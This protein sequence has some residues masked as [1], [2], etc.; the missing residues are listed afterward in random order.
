VE[1]G[2]ALMVNAW[3]VIGG[4]SSPTGEVILYDDDGNHTAMT[5]AELLVHAGARLEVV[6]PERTLGIEVGGMNMVSY[7]R[8]LNDADARISLTRRVRSIARR[9]DGMLDVELG[10]DHSEV[11][12]TRVVDAVVGDHG[13]ISNDTLFFELL[14]SSVNLGELDQQAFIDGEPQQ[15]RTN[16]TGTYQLFRIGDAVEHRN[17]HAAVYDALRLCKDL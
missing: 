1:S 16:A 8:A 5:T 2:Q 9:A 7:N 3:D 10:S 17:I 15:L 11:R 4:D 6:T 12:Q 14:P 13:A